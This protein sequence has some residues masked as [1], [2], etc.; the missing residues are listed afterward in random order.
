MFCVFNGHKLFKMNFLRSH[1]FCCEGN[2]HQNYSQVPPCKH[3]SLWGLASMCISNA[4]MRS[5]DQSPSRCVTAASPLLL[6][7]CQNSYWFKFFLSVFLRH[8]SRLEECS[9]ESDTRR[10][11]SWSLNVAQNILVKVGI[12]RICSSVCPRRGVP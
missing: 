1:S 3:V 11:V 4:A 10:G 7:L 6:A 8:S 12:R 2:T 9:D 5:N